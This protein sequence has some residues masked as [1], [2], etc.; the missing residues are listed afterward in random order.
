MNCT[1]YSYWTII[2]RNY[3]SRTCFCLDISVSLT[4]LPDYCAEMFLNQ[5][6]LDSIECQIPILNDRQS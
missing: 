3:D 2:F 6:S 4:T 5:G 1:G